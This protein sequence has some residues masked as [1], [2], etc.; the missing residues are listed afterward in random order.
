[1]CGS[2]Q[3]LPAVILALYVRWLDRWGVIAG[4]AV[5]I[6]L[7]T[8]WVVTNP[9]GL[10]SSTYKLDVFGWHVG[11][12]YPGFASFVANLV[13]VVVWSAV[14]VASAQARPESGISE[15][16]YLPNAAAV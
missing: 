8:Y 3:T 4:W 1:M 7:G 5:G 6:G 16:D 12:V 9:A 10:F 14:A 11:S 15:R 2:S 13:V